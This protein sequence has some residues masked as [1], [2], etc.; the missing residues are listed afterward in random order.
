MVRLGA[1]TEDEKIGENAGAL[2]GRLWWLVIGRLA[3][4]I[5]L[6]ILARTLF[7]REQSTTQDRGVLSI[8]VAVILLSVLYIIALRFLGRYRLQAGIQSFVDLLLVTWL[9]WMTGDVR[10]PYSAF[11]IVI[12]SVVSVLLGSRAALIA[13]VGCALFFT[14]IS[15]A[16]MA[17][18][19]APYA[20][21]AVELATSTTIET[22]GLNDIGFF[23]V[24]LLAAR[25]AERQS[26]SDVQ[27]IETTQTLATLRA[28]HERIVESI[29]SGV[30][31]TDLAGRIYTF[32][33]AAEEITGYRAENVRGQ[34]VSIFFGELKDHIAESMNAAAA[35][36][37]S[38]RFEADCLTAEG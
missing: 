29:R 37:P 19:I 1:M 38:P 33:A 4:A 14:G 28:L 34:E 26:R 35:A 10:S 8:F 13:S 23:V 12:I 9:V 27:L 16:V 7:A 3:A 18:I 22:V 17:G 21:A 31:T 15:L 20:R 24:G 2:R 6:F 36:E 11:Y 32:N 5:L 25:L 30:V